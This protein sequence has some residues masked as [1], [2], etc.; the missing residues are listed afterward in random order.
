M[1]VKPTILPIVVCLCGLTGAIIGFV[2]QWFTNAESIKMWALVWVEGYD[3]LVSGKPALSGAV[4]P[5]V[6]FELTVLLSAF[7]AVGGMLIFNWLPSLYHPLFKSERFR[8]VTDD[9]F[10]IVVESRDPKFSRAKTEAFL[11]TLDPLSIEALEA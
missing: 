5:I 2:L 1:G 10:F 9:R 3:F 4:Y 6:M 11:R 8:R 7:G